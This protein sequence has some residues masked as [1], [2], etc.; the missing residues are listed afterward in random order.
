MYLTN[1]FIVSEIYGGV[2]IPYGVYLDSGVMLL[3]PESVGVIIGPRGVLIK[4][5]DRLF[6]CRLFAGEE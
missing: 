3:A 6:V 1:R 4:V 2:A 5:F